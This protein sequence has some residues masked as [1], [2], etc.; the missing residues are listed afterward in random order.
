MPGL[1]K[2]SVTRATATWLTCAL[3]CVC[4]NVQARAQADGATK[5]PSAEPAKS[6]AKPSVFDLPRIQANQAAVRRA[7]AQLFARGDYQNA[8]KVLRQAI[9]RV[10][11]DPQNHYNLACALSR[12]RQTNPALDSLDRAVDLGFRNA[13]HIQQDNDLAPLRTH[14]RFKAIVQKATEPLADNPAKWNYKLTPGPIA[15]GQ[16]LVTEQ[17]TAWNAR[18]GL[19]VVLIN[20][21]P[22][23]TADKPIVNG[24]GQAGKLLQQWYKQGTAAGNHGDFYD[25]HDTEHSNMNFKAFGQLTRIEYSD[26]AKQRRLHHGLQRHFLFNGVTIGNSSTA[27][28]RGPYWRCQGRYALTQPRGAGILYLHYVRNH[29]YFYPEH[30]DHDPGHNGKGEKDKGYG[31]VFPANTP[32]LILSQGSSG[33]DRAFMNAVAATLAA[34]RPEVKQRLKKAGLIAP[35]VQMILRMSNKT[36]AQPKDYLTGKAHPTVFDGKQ[37]DVVK[38]VTMAQKIKADALPPFAAL[39]VVEEDEPMVGRDYFD[40]AAREKLL[41][42]PCAIGR[43]VK[44]S[45]YMRRMVI[46]AEASKDITEKPL[47]YHWKV[48]RGD[49][50]RIQIKKLNKA[51]SVVELLVPYHERGPVTPGSKME[52]NRVDIGAFVHNGVHYSA[53]AFISFYYLDNEKREYDAQKRIKSVD[54]TDPQVGGNYVDPMLDLKKDWRDEYQYNAGKLIGWTRIRKNQRQQFTAE[55]KLIVRTNAQGKPTATATVRYVAQQRDKKAPVLVQQVVG[56]KR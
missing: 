8:A 3:I 27:L 44:S 15:D 4:L 31:D 56:A 21:D 23:A 18:L 28:T 36:V 13:A 26:A 17:N 14:K 7:V 43:I 30:R 6:P 42:T 37:L 20:L 5:P 11:N 41:T 19:F 24:M 34:F 55:G 38:M 50:D 35:T 52:S 33:S 9:A 53:P 25:N 49:A 10:P 22:K 39:K 54:Y 29:I 46:S 48:L 2:R 45:K 1:I 40:I 47:T 32:Y 51:G 16:V 12:L